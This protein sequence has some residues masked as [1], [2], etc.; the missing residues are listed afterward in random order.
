MLL[1]KGATFGGCY[2]W[3]VEVVGATLRE[4]KLDATL[5][6]FEDVGVTLVWLKL[7]GVRCYS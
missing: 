3:K 6:E 4:L 7:V 5:R 2:S 1:L